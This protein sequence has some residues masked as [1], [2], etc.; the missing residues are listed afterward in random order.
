[1]Q[2]GN[3]YVVP[4]LPD[5]ITDDLESDCDESEFGCCQNISDNTNSIY[6]AHG[7]N[8]LGC[9]ASKE[10]QCCL[11]DRTPAEGPYSEG[12][13]DCKSSEFGCCPDNLTPAKGAN[14]SECGCRYSEHG[15]CPDSITQAVGPSFEGCGCETFEFG[16]CPDGERGGWGG[17]LQ[18]Y[19]DL[20]SFMQT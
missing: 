7:L 3:E 16:C 20:G 11:D 1:M 19:A 15:C 14:E 8:Q 9:C 2:I 17:R 18:V 12:C 4:N 5:Y 6:P 10:Y 13:P